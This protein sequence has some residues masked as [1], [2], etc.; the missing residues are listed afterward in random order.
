[1]HK[2]NKILTISRKFWAKNMLPSQTLTFST[3][4]P[5]VKPDQEKVTSLDHVLWASLRVVFCNYDLALFCLCSPR[6]LQ[7]QKNRC[8]QNILW[9]LDQSA[10]ENIFQSIAQCL[11]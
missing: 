4:Y 6:L 11:L 2:Q 8:L 1:M 5:F 10:T 3:L 9:N 7:L